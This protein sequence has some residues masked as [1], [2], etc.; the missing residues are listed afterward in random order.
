MRASERP[1]GFGHVTWA[2]RA[3][4]AG[5]MRPGACDAHTYRPRALSTE[6][7]SLSMGVWR[8]D[9]EGVPGTR[10]GGYRGI[11]RGWK[12]GVWRANKPSKTRAAKRSSMLVPR[13]AREHRD[14]GVRRSRQRR[15]KG[16]SVGS[17]VGI[18]CWLVPESVAGNGRKALTTR[19]RRQGSRV[20]PPGTR[21]TPR[22]WAEPPR[23]RNAVERGG[24]CKRAQWS[25]HWSRLYIFDVYAS[26]RPGRQGAPQDDAAGPTPTRQCL[27]APARLRH[28]IATTRRPARGPR[29]AG[30][31]GP[32]RRHPP[33][34]QRAP[35]GGRLPRS[36]LLLR[37]GRELLPIQHRAGRRPRRPRRARRSARPRS[38]ARPRRQP[39]PVLRGRA[40]GHARWAPCG[41]VLPDRYPT[42]RASIAGIP[43]AGPRVRARGHRAHGAAPRPTPHARGPD[44]RH[45]A[46]PHWPARWSS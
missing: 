46:R 6:V 15:T 25:R 9:P 13:A 11:P 32:T 23:S 12:Q 35:V 30:V 7:A 43:G 3:P 22:P 19:Q 14:N 33:D 44:S 36:R 8:G 34:R 38:R 40:I 10:N 20:T 4:D 1:A 28:G 5:G 37:P 16:S 29:R 18:E 41:L 21:Q 17:T 45:R 27:T 2:L 42:A 24:V 39:D 26:L 31:R